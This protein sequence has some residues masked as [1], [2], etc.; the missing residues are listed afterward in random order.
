[1]LKSSIAVLILMFILVLSTLNDVNAQQL[2]AHAI[3]IPVDIGQSVFFGF[4]VAPVPEGFGIPEGY[5]IQLD[6]ACNGT[7]YQVLV[8]AW[9]TDSNGNKYYGPKSEASDIYQEVYIPEIPQTMGLGLGA[10]LLFFLHKRR[11]NT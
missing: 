4:T 10:I 2:C 3:P 1:M 5:N 8:Q 7:A 9:A 6:P 11:R